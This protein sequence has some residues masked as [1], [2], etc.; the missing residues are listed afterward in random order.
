MG[1]LGLRDLGFKASG[2]GVK[3]LRFR[4]SRAWE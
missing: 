2:F 4:A 3:C 1:G